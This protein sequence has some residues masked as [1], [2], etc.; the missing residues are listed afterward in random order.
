M[1][2]DK[3]MYIPKDR[4]LHRM[5]LQTRLFRSFIHSYLSSQ[6]PKS[7]KGTVVMSLKSKH[8]PQ[9]KRL[10]VT[11]SLIFLSS[12]RYSSTTL[13]M[14]SRLAEVSLS[15]SYL[16]RHS[17][18][19]RLKDMAPLAKGTSFKAV[20]EWRTGVAMGANAWIDEDLMGK[21]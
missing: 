3:I 5:D 1:V 6:G 20:V 7:A 14:A 16:H 15:P 4:M 12:G 19:T 9:I 13:E 18:Q 17:R 2:S 21:K 11:S 8:P 10:T